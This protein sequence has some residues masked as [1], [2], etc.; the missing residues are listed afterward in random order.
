MVAVAGAA[1]GILAATLLGS[2]YY[3]GGRIDGL[4]SSLNSRIDGLERSLNDRI[5]SLAS[6]MDAHIER[7]VG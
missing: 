3:L 1:I 7:H 5:D 2:L 6:R 4:G